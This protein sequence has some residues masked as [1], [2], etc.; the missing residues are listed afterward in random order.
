V[1]EKTT[2]I[3]LIFHADLTPDQVTMLRVTIEHVI[4]EIARATV[5][6]CPVEVI[7]VGE[8]VEPESDAVVL[9]SDA[10]ISLDLGEV[11]R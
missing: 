5:G 3:S 4:G 1:A 10:G 2:T 7:A 8:T 6:V 9:G 11:A